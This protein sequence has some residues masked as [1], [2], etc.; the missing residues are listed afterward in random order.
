MTCDRICFQLEWFLMSNPK[1]SEC[2]SSNQTQVIWSWCT[3]M[4]LNSHSELQLIIDLFRYGDAFVG[5]WTRP[6]LVLL[7]TCYLFNTKS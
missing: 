7:T 5:L 4:G 1:L 2:A 3:A 6:S